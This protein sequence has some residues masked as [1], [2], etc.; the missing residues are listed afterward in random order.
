[1]SIKIFLEKVF[2]YELLSVKLFLFVLN[3]TFI[4]GCFS[5]QNNQDNKFLK[6]KRKLDASVVKNNKNKEEKIRSLRFLFYLNSIAKEKFSKKFNNYIKA[7]KQVANKEFFLVNYKNGYSQLFRAIDFEP[8]FGKFKDNE[9]GE[10]DQDFEYIIVDRSDGVRQIKRTFDFNLQKNEDDVLLEVKK[11]VSDFKLTGDEKYAFLQY[12]CGAGEL[13]K[14][15]VCEDFCKTS[16]NKKDLEGIDFEKTS[17]NKISFDKK[18]LYQVNSQKKDCKNKIIWQVKSGV[19]DFLFSLDNNYVMVKILCKNNKNFLSCSCPDLENANC[20]LNFFCNNLDLDNGDSKIIVIRLKDAKVV[21]QEPENVSDVELSSKFNYI[22]LIFSDKEY[23]YG[24]LIKIQDAELKNNHE[25]KNLFE[26]VVDVKFSHDENYIVVNSI[27]KFKL[28][29][30]LFNGNNF[31]NISKMELIRTPD[32]FLVG[33]T[34]G[35]LALIEFSPDSGYLCV[36]FSSG[37]VQLKRT[38]DFKSI[39][40]EICENICNVKHVVFS[41]NSDIVAFFIEDLQKEGSLFLQNANA[42]LGQDENIETAIEFFKINGLDLIKINESKNYFRLDG[43]EF[44]SEGKTALISYKNFS[45]NRTE[46][47][48][49]IEKEL[50]PTFKDSFSDIL[51]NGLKNSSK[52]VYKDSCFDNNLNKDLNKNCGIKVKECHFFDDK[53]LFQQR[54]KRA[55]MFQVYKSSKQIVPFRENLKKRIIEHADLKRKNGFCDL[56]V[57]TRD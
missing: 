37:K 19:Q 29:K 17:N 10:F 24:K 14:L 54:D 55:K 50:I 46:K 43:V 13:V 40:K 56:K 42:N 34:F 11:D 2:V 30:T 35:D 21:W 53:I 51:K 23:R 57:L 12:D 22:F 32:L 7:I 26:N 31:I 27:N 15:N 49:K 28:E 25:S 8:M 41:K 18:D 44:D 1:M 5:M 45:N 3:M 38:K 4:N 6:F 39:G 16:F 20:S 48:L 36:I 47:K 52:N 33:E 9:N